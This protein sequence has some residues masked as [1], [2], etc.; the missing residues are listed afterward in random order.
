M[1][2]TK[3]QATEEPDS[4]DE[5]EEIEDA[6]DASDEDEENICDNCKKAYRQTGYERIPR[7]DDN[8]NINPTV[9]VHVPGDSHRPSLVSQR[10]SGSYRRENNLG[11]SARERRH[12]PRYAILSGVGCGSEPVPTGAGHP[13][14]RDLREQQRSEHSSAVGGV[15]ENNAKTDG[16]RPTNVP[17]NRITN[18]KRATRLHPIHAEVISE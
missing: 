18:N 8:A 17:V 7:N 10:P 9:R 4:G 2:A 3:R 6:S 14:L 5:T 13:S 11:N 12:D 1:P 16:G 15:D